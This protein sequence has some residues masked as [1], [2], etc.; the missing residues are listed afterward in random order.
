MLDLGIAL[1]EAL[2]VLNACACIYMP[3]LEDQVS[4]AK[5]SQFT[6]AV[7]QMGLGHILS[8]ITRLLLPAIR[9]E[10]WGRDVSARFARGKMGAYVRKLL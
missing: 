9:E 7:Q 5:I 3:V 8:K 4:A 10:S 2:P 1:E 6:Q